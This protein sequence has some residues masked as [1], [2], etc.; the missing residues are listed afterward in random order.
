[1]SRERIEFCKICV[2]EYTFWH[3]LCIKLSKTH[4]QSYFCWYSSLRNFWLFWDL[5]RFP[6]SFSA[7]RPTQSMVYA[8]FQVNRFQNLILLIVQYKYL[9]SCSRRFILQNLILRTRLCGTM[10]ITQPSCVADFQLT[11]ICQAEMI[12][13]GGL[14]VLKRHFGGAGP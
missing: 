14:P 3:S 5:L 9:K 13:I 6:S 1:M 11:E 7:I 2:L 4:F 12:W 10:F 8:P